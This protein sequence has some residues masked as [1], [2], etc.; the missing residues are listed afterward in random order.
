MRVDLGDFF[1]ES[2]VETEFDKLPAEY[3]YCSAE[4]EYPLL[5][6]PMVNPEWIRQTYFRVLNNF[7]RRDFARVFQGASSGYDIDIRYTH[8]YPVSFFGQALSPLD[9]AMPLVHAAIKEKWNVAGKI[10]EVHGWQ[11]LGYDKGYNFVNH[12]DNSIYGGENGTYWKI[13]TPERHFS[14]LMYLNNCVDDVYKKPEDFS[15]GELVFARIKNKLTGEA[16]R[17]KPK[18]GV[19]YIFPSNPIF[20][21]EVTPVTAGYRVSVVNWLNVTATP[22]EIQ[23][24]DVELV[25]DSKA[26][27]NF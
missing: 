6:V 1:F 22:K 11:L 25:D 10:K 26:V 24:K 20:C 13:N 4:N 9:N 8:C 19:A 5:T 15:G 2:T 12:C 17:I 21:H 16:L 18:A 3:F 27:F 14:F 23:R 7:H